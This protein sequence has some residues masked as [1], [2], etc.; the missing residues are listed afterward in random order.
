LVVEGAPS[1]RCR[2]DQAYAPVSAAIR[3][4]TSCADVWSPFRS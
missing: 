4:L 1:E 2:R 3:P